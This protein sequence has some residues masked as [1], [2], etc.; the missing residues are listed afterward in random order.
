MSVSKRN[1]DF[2]NLVGK[3]LNQ[4]GAK[5]VNL[6]FND[7]SM[8]AAIRDFQTA[9]GLKPTGLADDKTF[10]LLRKPVAS[11]TVTGSAGAGNTGASVKGS[12]PVDNPDAVKPGEFADFSPAMQ[13]SAERNPAIARRLRE[14]QL[15]EGQTQ[16][17]KAAGRDQHNAGTVRANPPAKPVPDFGNAAPYQARPASE[18]IAPHNQDVALSRAL[19]AKTQGLRDTAIDITPGVKG[20]RPPDSMPSGNIVAEAARPLRRRRH[21]ARTLAAGGG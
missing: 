2:A 18:G 11:L 15:A 21:P 16:V 19:N 13:A 14:M 10:R 3:L 12:V 6:D 1:R 17:D 5:L 7:Q 20:Y 8:Q 4:R 9:N